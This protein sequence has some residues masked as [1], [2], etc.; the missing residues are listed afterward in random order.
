MRLY[1][2]AEERGVRIGQGADRAARAG[3]AGEPGGMQAEYR[4]VLQRPDRCC[5]RGSVRRWAGMRAPSSRTM[6]R[7]WRAGPGRRS[8]DR[9]RVAGRP[10]PAGWRCRL[11]Q[12]IARPKSVLWSW[13]DSTSEAK[14]DCASQ[15]PVTLTATGRRVENPP[16][17]PT[18]VDDA[19]FDRPGA[20]R[21]SR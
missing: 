18:Q 12:P 21:P 13:P 1:A 5:V 7:S 10:G 17:W 20:A 14:R 16:S 11:P 8:S 19:H 9:G 2:G 3:T 6:G 15:A 4:K